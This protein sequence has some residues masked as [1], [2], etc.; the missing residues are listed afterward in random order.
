MVKKSKADELIDVLKFTTRKMEIVISGY[1]GEIVMGRVDLDTY[2]YWQNTSNDN[3]SEFVMGWDEE[4]DTVPDEFQFVSPGCWYDCDDI[5]HASG[6]EMHEYCTLTVIDTT[7]NEAVF[8]TT[9]D[10]Y[11]L[12][13]AGV[14]VVEH[15]NIEVCD[16][17]DGT[18]VF[19]GQSVEKGTFYATEFEIDQPFDPSKLVINYSS[20]NDWPIA[21]SVFYNGEDLNGEDGYSTS[22]KSSNFEIVMYGEE[23]NASNGHEK[24]NVFTAEKAW[25]LREVN[26]SKMT[27]WFEYDRYSPVYSGEYQVRVASTLYP[28]QFAVWKDNKWQYD[29]GE[30]IVLPVTSWRG[31]NYDTNA[32]KSQ[33]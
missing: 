5:G 17:E 13:D 28:V 15:E 14:T 20:Y 31:L 1:G 30:S 10:I 18:A 8:T 22:G 32:A 3:L 16:V 23:Y 19:I 2:R 11:K 6:V 24:D 26:E 21:T 29:N 7:T 27:E 33:Q 25:E 4:N 12:E 9:M